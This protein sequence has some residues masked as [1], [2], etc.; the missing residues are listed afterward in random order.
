LPP[1]PAAGAR[2]RLEVDY[3]AAGPEAAHARLEELDPEAAAAVH[4]NDRRRVVRA[5]ELA[6]LGE[7]LVPEQGRLWTNE[8]RH[9]TLIFGLAVAPDVLADRIQRRARAMFEA[10]AE[11]EVHAALAAGPVSATARYAHGLEEIAS[12]P[13]GKAL[14]ALIVR[15]RRYAAYQRKWMRRIP[16]LVAVDAE[17]P[18][19]EVAA[20][21]VSITR[22]R[23][24]L[25]A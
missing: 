17:R 12:L 19:D 15:S 3:D 8:T 13:S 21:I 1:P 6:E 9:P 18:A 22:D 23:G 10:G 20:E 7:S 24:I 11:D 2:E 25:A 4:A 5:L 14:D 16:S